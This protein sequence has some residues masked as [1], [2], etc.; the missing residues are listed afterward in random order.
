MSP[1]QAAALISALVPLTIALTSQAYI[2]IRHR[3]QTVWNNNTQFGEKW[4]SKHQSTGIKQKKADGDEREADVTL[5]IR[6]EMYIYVIANKCS[7]STGGECKILSLIPDLSRIEIE[8]CNL[9]LC[10]AGSQRPCDFFFLSLLLS[11]I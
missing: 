4:L 8:K 2:K 7:H 9:F 10:V 3:H 5:G 1:P 11:A 6:K